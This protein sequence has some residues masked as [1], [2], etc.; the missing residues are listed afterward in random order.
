MI[1][2]YKGFPVLISALRSVE[3][4]LV[5]AGGVDEAAQALLAGGKGPV[6]DNLRYWAKAAAAA[7]SGLI[8]TATSCRTADHETNLMI[9]DAAGDA[10]EAVGT[11]IYSSE[12]S[13]SETAFRKACGCGQSADEGSYKYGCPTGTRRRSQGELSQSFF[14]F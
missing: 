6:M 3:Q 8:A 14:Y 13:R 11:R 9:K 12:F 7:A 10:Q 2:L 4:M 5:A 1:L